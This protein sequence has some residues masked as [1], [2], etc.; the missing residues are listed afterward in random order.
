MTTWEVI[1]W[2]EVR[3]LLFN[4]VLLV[5]GFGS[6]EA[7][8]FLISRA[9]PDGGSGMEAFGLALGVLFYGLAANICYT[10]GWIVELLGRKGGESLARSRAKNHFWLGLWLSGLLTTAPFWFGLVY[11]WLH[12]S[13]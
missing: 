5:V 3:R 2:W 11:W 12:R 7:M 10:S 13:R 4:G 6:I 8:D 9:T 1:R